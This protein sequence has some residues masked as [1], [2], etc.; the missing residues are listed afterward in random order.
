MEMDKPKIDELLETFVNEMLEEPNAVLR[1]T[2]ELGADKFAIQVGADR[3]RAVRMIEDWCS[4]HGIKITADFDPKTGHVASAADRA[5]DRTVR[6][7]TFNPEP[8]E[9][10]PTDKP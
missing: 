3:K 10:T 2:I 9:P 1:S 7:P 5:M 8:A 4:E 6:T